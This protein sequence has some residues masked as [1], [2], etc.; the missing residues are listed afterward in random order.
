M[1]TLKQLEYLIA[2]QADCLAK[3]DWDSFDKAE[4]EIKKLEKAILGGQ[5]NEG[6]NT[7]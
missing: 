6:L 7:A 5:E 1:E 4:N 2:F 3:G